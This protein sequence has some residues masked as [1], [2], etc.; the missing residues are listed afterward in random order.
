V[1]AQGSVGSVPTNVSCELVN[2]SQSGSSGGTDHGGVVPFGQFGVGVEVGVA[3]AVGTVVGAGVGL[4]VGVGDT[5]GLGDPAVKEAITIAS[6][7]V[8]PVGAVACA[9]TERNWPFADTVEM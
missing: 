4:G 3:L 2:P 8:E 5:V 1:A 6:L 7:K 9:K